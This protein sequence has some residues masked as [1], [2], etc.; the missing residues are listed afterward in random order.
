MYELSSTSP[1]MAQEWVFMLMLCITSIK[2]F[3][4]SLTETEESERSMRSKTRNECL[5][6]AGTFIAI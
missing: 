1:G 6:L 3:Q 4:T 2:K 5:N